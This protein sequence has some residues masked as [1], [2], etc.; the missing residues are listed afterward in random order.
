MKSPLMQFL[1]THIRPKH[2]QAGSNPFGTQ[3]EA[4]LPSNPEKTVALRKLL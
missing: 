1:N 2:L 4:M 3:I